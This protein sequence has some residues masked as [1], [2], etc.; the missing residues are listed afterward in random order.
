MSSINI[1]QSS[2]VHQRTGIL[3]SGGDFFSANDN[4]RTVIVQNLGTN[5]LFVKFGT[6]ASSSDFDVVLKGGTAPDDGLGGTVSFDVLSY[7]GTISSAGTSPRF[8][9]TD[10]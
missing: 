6:G 3:T 7:T 4:R 10:F 5:P 1:D 9:A 8:T 2:T